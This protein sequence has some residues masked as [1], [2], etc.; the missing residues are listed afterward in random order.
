[1]AV[2]M[3]LM[4]PYKTYTVGIWS[5]NLITT[6]G[7]KHSFSQLPWHKK[8]LLKVVAFN[9]VMPYFRGTKRPKKFF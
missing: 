7:T 6:S 4:S 1:M 9:K 5:P 2:R 8:E 3:K